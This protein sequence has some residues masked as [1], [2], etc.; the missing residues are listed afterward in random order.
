MSKFGFYTDCH[1]TN[2]HIRNDNYKQTILNKLRSI[3]RQAKL[4]NF[5]FMTFGGDFFHT[6]KVLDIG[7]IVSVCEIL[8]QF[9]KP[10]YVLIGNHDIYGNSLNG[11]HDSTLSLL[12]TILPQLF[13]PLF[14]PIQLDDIIIYGCNT[15]NDLQY[16]IQHIEKRQDK[17]Q[18]M[19][20]HHM[21]YDKGINGTT[22]IHPKQLGENNL[23]LILSGH[24]HMGYPLYTYGNTSYYNPGSLS[25]TSRDLKDM[26]V[27]MAIISTNKKKFELG[28]FYPQILDGQTIFKQS[29]FSGIERITKLQQQHDVNSI[30]SFKHFQQLKYSSSSIFELLGKLGSEKNI[31]EDVINYI[32]GFKK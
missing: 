11:Y 9:G 15:F 16:T 17:F 14:N 22:I 31:S 4:Q 19:L 1:F 3:Y 30:E 12:C 5:D 18:L 32:N 20:D 10:T 27:S 2:H 8:K 7:I 28:N 24:V 23:D 21:I 6:H 26:K 29:V 13:V 25:R